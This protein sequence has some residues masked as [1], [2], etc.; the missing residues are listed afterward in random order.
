MQ[1]KIRSDQFASLR[2]FTYCSIQTTDGPQFTVA[3]DLNVMNYT[4]QK[5]NGK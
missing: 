2:S 1:H 5:Q 4:L 3:L